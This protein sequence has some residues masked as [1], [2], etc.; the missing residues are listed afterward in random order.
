MATA[1]KSPPMI[2]PGIKCPKCGGNM[3]DERA[4]KRSEKSPDYTCANMLCTDASGKYRTAIWEKDA[5]GNG[6][7]APGNPPA[8]S[9][10]APVAES[11]KPKLSDMY[12]KA[13][14][15]VLEKIVPLYEKAEIGLSDGAVAAMV[16]TLFIAATKER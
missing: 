16:A 2:A 1:T 13:T 14:D 7:S 15:F 9:A 11:D 4:T 5:K 12:L 3:L 6:A 10:A 8:A